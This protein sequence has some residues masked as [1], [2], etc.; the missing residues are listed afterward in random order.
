MK[1]HFYGKLDNL[2]SCFT[3]QTFNIDGVTILLQNAPRFGYRPASLIIKDP[4][5]F[6]KKE[7]DYYRFVVEDFQVEVLN[8]TLMIDEETIIKIIENAKELI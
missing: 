3:F 7:D 4:A 2:E 8:G 5:M 1:V 6:I